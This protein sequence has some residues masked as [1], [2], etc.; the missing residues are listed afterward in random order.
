IPASSAFELNFVPGISS[1]G[2]A[3]SDDSWDCSHESSQSPLSDYHCRY[4]HRTSIS[5][6]PSVADLYPPVTSPVL[7]TSITAV[8]G[9]A[10]VLMPPTSFP[11]PLVAAPPVGFAPVSLHGPRA[12]C[13]FA[14]ADQLVSGS[15]V[16]LPLSNLDG[17]EWMVIRRELSAGP[18]S[19]SSSD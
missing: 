18:A 14:E 17:D 3:S 19:F 6:S 16:Q 7:N 13:P 11:S 12:V 8:P 10:S 1:A 9:W 15:A 5:S 4:P 2:I